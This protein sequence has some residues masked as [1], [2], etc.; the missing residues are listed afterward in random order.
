MLPTE[1]RPLALGQALITPVQRTRDD[2][3]PVFQQGVALQPRQAKSQEVQVVVGIAARAQVIQ[4]LIDPG[5]DHA[6]APWLG[7]APVALE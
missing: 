7:L 2:A 3:L 1:H 6:Q 4:A 5:T